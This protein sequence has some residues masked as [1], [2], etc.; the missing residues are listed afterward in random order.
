MQQ[1][2]L[3]SVVMP[4]HN[5]GKYLREAAESILNQTYA[6]LEFIII[7]DGSTDD[8]VSIIS[9]LNDPRIILYSYKQKQGL[10]KA[11]NKGFEL[12]KG[13]YIARM[14]ADDICLKNRI[15]QQVKYMM[16]NPDVGILGTQIIAIGSKARKLPV[17]H[18]AITWHLLNACP[19]LH[20]S[21]VFKRSTI[22]EHRLF[23]DPRFDGAEDLELWVRASQVT[24][25][26]NLDKAYVKY[27]YHFGTHRAM[28]AVV[29]RLNTEIKIKHLNQIMP[30]LPGEVKNSLALFMNRHIKHERT[31]LWLEK[32]LASFETALAQYPSYVHELTNEFNKCLWFH[33]SSDPG[34]YKKVKKGLKDHQWFRL[35]LKQR[36]WL[37][38]KPLLKN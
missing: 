4:M 10:A 6:R 25:L 28:I 9:S 29:G 3:I 19:F 8:G 30:A 20:P 24:G 22:L 23:Y 14:D 32:G 26:A 12:A 36:L 11:L 37:M 34:L 15:E 27:R 2:P 21:V 35:S 17:T 1:L 38:L 18:K 16:A 7:D 33:F 5:A 13:E 31:L